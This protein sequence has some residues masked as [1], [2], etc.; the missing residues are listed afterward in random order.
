[1]TI[2]VKL[3]VADSGKAYLN[4]DK[5]IKCTN[6]KLKGDRGLMKFPIKLLKVLAE[7][8]EITYGDYYQS[9]VLLIDFGTTIHEFA[10][11]GYLGTPTS[12]TG[13]A[14]SLAQDMMKFIDIKTWLADHCYLQIGQHLRGLEM[15]ETPPDS[16]GFEGKVGVYNMEWDAKDPNRISFDFSFTHGFEIDW[17]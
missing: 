5:T 12:D 9:P 15:F 17:W 8:L 13:I 1:M 2:D 7:F 16:L 11:K 10:V 14:E 4:D 3:I 6:W